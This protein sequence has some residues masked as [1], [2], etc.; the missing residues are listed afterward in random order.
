MVQWTLSVS[1]LLPAA[2]SARGKQ[3]V[4]KETP[5]SVAI[6]LTPETPCPAEVNAMDHSM[7]P[8]RHGEWHHQKGSNQFFFKGLNCDFGKKKVKIVILAGRSSASALAWRGESAVDAWIWICVP[9]CISCISTNKPI[10]IVVQEDCLPRILKHLKAT[11]EKTLIP[12]RIIP[13]VH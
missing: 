2:A 4:R 5:W 12:V 7:Q 1:A 8:K 9:A 10:P 11:S 6:R 3:S 13:T